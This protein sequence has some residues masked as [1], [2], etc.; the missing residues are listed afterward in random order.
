[1]K[2]D[3]VALNPWAAPFSESVL[4]WTSP[5]FAVARREAACHLLSGDASALRDWTLAMEAL[6]AAAGPQEP[7]ASLWSA[8]AV[9]DASDAQFDGVIDGAAMT[10]PGPVHFSRTLF[11]AE[12][13]FNQARFRGHVDFA[14][15]RCS[16]AGAWLEGGQFLAGA[17]FTGACFQGTVECRGT[18]FVG[19]V[20]LN[21]L[22]VAKHFWG[23][24]MRF[25]GPVFIENARFEG[26]VH[27][28]KSCFEGPVSFRNAVFA[29]TVTFTGAT[30]PGSVDFQGAEF[31]GNVW[32]DQARLGA[33]SSFDL[34]RFQGKVTTTG[35]EIAQAESSAS[36]D[37]APQQRVDALRGSGSILEA[38]ARQNKG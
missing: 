5:E 30:F 27:F 16:K 6:G 38:L 17:D 22:T 19:E 3:L 4:G 26:E 18:L 36:H 32:F 1:M 15:A 13:Y 10:F 8:L 34:A 12:A 33:Q 2:Q 23:A 35:M 29:D 14:D 28:G 9:L 11:G 7:L 21:R 37:A 25:D 20:K 24:G 31:Q